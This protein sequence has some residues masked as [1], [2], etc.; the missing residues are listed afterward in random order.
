[1]DKKLLTREFM[2]ATLQGG[3]L[4]IETF[5]KIMLKC[6]ELNGGDCKLSLNEFLELITEHKN[7]CKKMLSTHINH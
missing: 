4:S 6:A 2:T 7:N 5:E 3:L 1:M